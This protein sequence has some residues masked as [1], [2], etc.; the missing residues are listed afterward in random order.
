MV[1]P[2]I[3]RQTGRA[4][5]DHFPFIM[6][7]ENNSVTLNERRNWIYS[8]PSPQLLQLRPKTGA[9]TAALDRLEG[10]K[11]MLNGR[12]APANERGVM[13]NDLIHLGAMASNLL[14]TAS[15]LTVMEMR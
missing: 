4:A 3:P 2:G 9:H 15:N 14:A 8:P 7:L 13:S 5:W 10:P 12:G 6:L 1:V 11:G